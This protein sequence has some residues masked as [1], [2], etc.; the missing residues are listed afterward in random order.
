MKLA[1]TMEATGASPRS[2]SAERA[3]GANVGAD[4]SS[5]QVP[6]CPS[7]AVWQRR[8]VLRVAGA[9]LLDDRDRGGVRAALDE[10]S[11]GRLH[12]RS[13]GRGRRA[14]SVAARRRAVVG[15]LAP[16]RAVLLRGQPRAAA[17]R[18]GRAAQ[19][20]DRARRGG[21]SCSSIV[22]R[23]ELV[24]PLWDDL[25]VHWA[26]CPRGARRPAADG[27]GRPARGGARPVRAPGAARPSWSATCRPPS[28]CS[29]R[30][31]ASTRGRA[32][33]ARATASRVSELVVGGPRV[34]PVRGRPGRVQG[35]DRRALRAGRADPG[36]LGAPGLPRPRAGHGGHR[37]G[38]RPARRRWAGCRASTSTGSTTRP[39][40]L[41]ADRLHP[42]RQLR[43]HPVL[44]HGRQR[45]SRC[46]SGA[47]TAAR[48]PRRSAA[49]TATAISNA[50]SADPGIPR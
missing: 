8:R 19:F 45:L 44:T 34:R 13:P 38:R 10:R 40:A 9:R 17:R 42:G 27:A 48:T 20:A 47:P 22:G 23:A 18:P 6:S 29:P 37:G 25:A 46:G 7:A 5:R 14:G 35:R 12:G 3:C 2:R 24:L 33:A 15:G 32:T 39:A 43:H 26:P 16:G 36:R 28:R 1:E 30:R 11:G 50:C 41:R 49:A 31:S 4:L 21:R